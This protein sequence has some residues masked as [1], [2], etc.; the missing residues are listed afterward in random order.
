MTQ[1]SNSNNQLERVEAS[2]GRS[3][4]LLERVIQVQATMLGTQT[5]QQNALMS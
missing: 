4:N 5:Q 3:T 2:L 1:A